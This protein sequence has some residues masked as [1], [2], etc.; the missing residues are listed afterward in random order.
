M[1]RFSSP[2]DPSSKARV[3]GVPAGCPSLD[4]AVF[5]PIAL[6]EVITIYAGKS[7]ANSAQTAE[8]FQPNPHECP[9]SG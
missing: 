9:Q 5:E 1:R 8:G 7:R 4:W 6:L 2:A 3:G